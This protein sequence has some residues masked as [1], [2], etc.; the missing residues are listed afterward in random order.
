M[1]AHWFI[2][3]ITLVAS[4]FAQSN[5]APAA[6]K[7]RMSFDEFFNGTDISDVNISPDGRSVLIGTAR[8]DWDQEVNRRDIWLWTEGSQLR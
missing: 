4:T 1:R 5:P 2:V 6:N 8:P 7:P 3:L